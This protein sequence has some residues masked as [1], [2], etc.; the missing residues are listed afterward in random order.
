VPMVLTA[1]SMPLLFSIADA[2][3]LGVIV[4]VITKIISGRWK[5]VKVATYILAL[6]FA[7]SLTYLN[8]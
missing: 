3:A 5:D 4:F 6:I 8:I 7:A 2:I 1:I